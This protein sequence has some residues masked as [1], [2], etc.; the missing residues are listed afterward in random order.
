MLIT[1]QGAPLYI[2]E[3]SPPNLRGSLLVLESVSVVTGVVIAYWLTYG[4]RHIH[5]EAC[6]R[7]P[8]GL[9]MV[10]STILGF[11]IHLFPYSP[12][13]L[14]LVGRNDDALQS[15]SK[16]RRLPPSDERIMIELRGIMA[17]VDF[18][19]QMLEK[20]HPGKKGIALEVALWLDLLHRKNWRRTIVGCGVAFFQQCKSPIR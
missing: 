5:G 20:H 6:F 3:I 4:T 16:L 2:S 14:S 19:T 18:Q 1:S 11:A 12:R 13:W 17:E 9:Q 10:C 15:L 8:L 7:V